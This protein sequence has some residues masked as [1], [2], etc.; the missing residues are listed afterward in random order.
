MQKHVMSIG[1]AAALAIALALPVQAG[2]AGWT[3]SYDEAVKTAGEKDLFILVDF[4]GSDWCGWC[5]RLKAE[6]FDQDPHR[7][8]S[9]AAT[10]SR[11]SS[12]ALPP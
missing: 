5:K 12:F 6:V 4:T 1:A 2:G 3:T 7:R 9:R 11:A 8:P 10:I